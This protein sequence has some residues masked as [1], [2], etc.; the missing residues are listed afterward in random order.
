MML[1]EAVFLGAL[2]LFCT[3]VEADRISG[4]SLQIAAAA[5]VLFIFGS[6]EEVGSKLK[7]FS[8]QLGGDKIV[9]PVLS[10]GTF[11][12]E[13]VSSYMT[14]PCLEQHWF[15]ACCTGECC[16]GR[17]LFSSKSKCKF[18]PRCIHNVSCSGGSELQL[19]VI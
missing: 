16:L 12:A 8:S 5:D 3:V 6:A 18:G 9:V 11:S 1:S 4:W 7:D 19:G 10:S 2:H 13:G 14:N 15:I 17:E